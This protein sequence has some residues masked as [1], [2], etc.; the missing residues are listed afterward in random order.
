MSCR[1]DWLLYKSNKIIVVFN[2]LFIIRHCNGWIDKTSV[3]L[4][5]S[6]SAP[7]TGS[8]AVEERHQAACIHKNASI[9][10]VT[11]VIHIIM[12]AGTHD[13]SPYF[14][15]YSETSPNDH[16]CAECREN[17]HHF[18]PFS[19]ISISW[20]VA[21]SLREILSQRRQP[22]FHKKNI[23]KCTKVDSSKKDLIH[24]VAK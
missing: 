12:S 2:L 18:L 9:I 22:S 17:N 4:L 13:K 10:R 8:L 14:Q 23:T 24:D 15:I 3:G 1:V 16:R 11:P 6:R 20:W 21:V 5:P 19:C 7:P